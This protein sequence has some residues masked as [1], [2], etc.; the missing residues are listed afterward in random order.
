[1]SEPVVFI[2]RQRIKPGKLEAYKQY[3]AEVAALTE[4]KRPGTVA[5]VAY[6]N[7]AGDEAAIVQVF[8]DAEAMQAHM[9]S[10]GRIAERASEF[11]E[12]VDWQIFGRPNTAVLEVMLKL[13]GPKVTLS[14]HP[15]SI[16]GYLRFK[17]E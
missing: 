4:A 5:H 15:H 1:M 6:L 10:A 13:A 12:V 14:I 17:P 8:R 16:G 3:Y 2:S 9:R 11:M 7:E